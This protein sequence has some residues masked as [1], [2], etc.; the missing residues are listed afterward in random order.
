MSIVL[1]VSMVPVQ[2]LAAETSAGVTDTVMETVPAEE[3][4]DPAAEES[5]PVPEETEA[6]TEETE[7]ATEAS[8]PAPEETRSAVEETTPALLDPSSQDMASRESAAGASDV[9]SE[10]Y[11]QE[12]VDSGDT[13]PDIE[14][15]VV[16]EKSF[17]WPAGYRF[18]IPA[19]ITLTVSAG[20]TLTMNESTSLSGTI[21]VENGGTFIQNDS[22]H[23][24]DGGV[25]RVNA[26]GTLRLNDT[27]IDCYSAGTLEV[28]GTFEA[29]AAA[30]GSAG[31]VY[32][33]YRNGV[34]GKVSGIP[35]G[36]LEPRCIVFTE[37]QLREVLANQAS[38]SYKSF[39]ASIERDLVLSSAITISSGCR[40]KV[41]SGA[42]LTLGKN[43]TLTNHGTF[44]VNDGVISSGG[45]INNYGWISVSD[46]FS[47][48]G[49][50]DQHSGSIT[51]N[52]TGVFN[53]NG[54]VYGTQVTMN[55][56]WY[57]PDPIS[58]IR[59]EKY[60]E[61][62]LNSGSKTPSVTADVVL[63]NSFTI[64]GNIHK[65]N[66]NATITI[67]AGKTLTLD[68]T[69]VFL[70][71]GASIV[72]EQG[73]TLIVNASL[74][75]WG[76]S[77]VIN[78]GTIKRTGSWGYII[79]NYEGREFVTHTEGV[80]S[81][82]L[83]LRFIIDNDADLQN[84][85]QVMA[86]T[87]Y[88]HYILLV[89]GD[90]D[91]SA[92]VTIPAN[93]E[94]ML[95]DMP[96]TMTI[97]EGKT[98]TNHGTL[99]VNGDQA[100]HNLGTVESDGPCSISGKVI[101]D[102]RFR[103]T[104]E[105][106]VFGIWE[107][108]PPEYGTVT[109]AEI[110]AG[111]K[112][113]GYYVLYGNATLERSMTLNGHLTIEAGRSLT[114]P[115]GVK[116][117]VAA[118]RSISVLSGGTLVMNGTY[119]LK[120]NA[121][122]WPSA[123]Y[124][125]T[126]DGTVGTITGIREED[127]QVNGLVRN[128]ANFPAV[129]EV[130]ARHPNAKYSFLY[131]YTSLELPGD[132]V[133]PE[134]CFFHLYGGAVLTIPKN[135]TLTN[136]GQ[137]H[138][139]N[140]QSVKNNGTV[141]NRNFFGVFGSMENAGQMH[142][143]PG[144]LLVVDPNATLTNSGTMDAYGLDVADILGTLSGNPINYHVI[145]H[146]EFEAM[147]TEAAAT[148]KVVTLEKAVALEKNLTIPETVSLEVFNGGSILVPKDVALTL[149]CARV[150][151]YKGDLIVQKG[152]TL[153]LNTM[154]FMGYNGKLLVD[155]RFTSAG[156]GYE[157]VNFFEY[158]PVPC[159]VTGVPMASQRLHVLL[160]DRSEYWQPG[161]ELFETSA[162]SKVFLE[163]LSDVTLPVDL[164]IPKNGYLLIEGMAQ[165]LVV[166][167][168]KKLTNHGVLRV[169]EAKSL[170]NY[171]T[172]DNH[173]YFYVRANLF[174]HGTIHM[175]PAAAGSA[176]P[177]VMVMPKWGYVENHG[178]VT[179][180]LGTNL[181]QNAEALWEGNPAVWEFITQDQLESAMAEA[182]EK[183]ETYTLNTGVAL[184]RTLTL[185]QPLTIGSNGHL[186]VPKGIALNLKANLFVN[187]GGRL[188]V[189]GTYTA[190]ED[191]AVYVR[192][193]NGHFSSQV[194]GIRNE[195]LMVSMLILTEAHLRDSVL[196]V[197]N[198]GYR[199]GSLDVYQSFTLTGDITIPANGLVHLYNGV[200]LTVGTG[201][202]LTNNGEIYIWEGA[203]LRN[204][205]TI[206]NNEGIF[207]RG[208]TLLNNGTL[209]LT[210][211]TKVSALNPRLIL[212]AGTVK[213][214][215]TVTMAKNSYLEVFSTWEG[216]VPQNNGG[217]ILPQAQ[218]L[219][220]EGGENR[221]V[222]IRQNA[223]IDLKIVAAGSPFQCVTWTS[224]NSAV[225]NPDRIENLGGGIYRV[226][227]T[228]TGKAKL[229]A[230][231]IDG[232]KLTAVLNMEIERADWSP[233]L[234]SK[235]VTVNPMLEFSGEVALMP[236]HNNHIVDCRLND[237]RFQV[238]Y[239]ES[240]LLLIGAK[241]PI[242]NG[243]VSAVL[244]VTCGRD[245]ETYTYPLTITVKNSAP[246]VTIKQE[247][248]LNLFYTD[249]SAGLTVT[250]KNAYVERVE[251]TD[252]EDFRLEGRT[253]RVTDLFIR[254]YLENPKLKPD[255]KATVLV[256]LRGYQQPVSTQITIGTTTGKPA[257]VT[258][259]ASGTV[260]TALGKQSL[261][262]RVLDK[263]TKAA[264]NL[265]ASDIQSVDGSFVTGWQVEDG[266]L[267]L[268]TAGEKG[269]TATIFL[270]RSNWTQSVKVTHKVTINAKL[271]TA[272]P[273]SSTLKLSSVFSGQSARTQV[274]LSHSNLT[275]DGFR[276]DNQFVSTAKAG[277][278]A[279]Q[280]ASKLKVFYNKED[281]TITAGIA[282]GTS[283]PKA[284][285]YTFSAVPV[286]GGTELKAVTIK[287]NV[288]STLP[289]IKLSGSSLKLNTRLSGSEAGKIG[290]TLNDTTGYGLKVVGFEGMDTY[291]SQIAMT[292]SG[293]S[294][295]A[296]LLTK[297]TGT[298]TYQLV[299]I[300]ADSLG[301]TAKLSPVKVT[302]Q[303]YDKDITVTTSAKGSLD[304]ICRD[305]AI[306]YTI[307][308][309]GNALDKVENVELVQGGE[310]FG[311]SSIMEDAKG[312]QIFYLGVNVGTTV[313]VKESY[314]VQ[315]R[316]TICG[317]EVLSKVF[318]VKVRQSALKITAPA[319]TY[320]LTQQAPIRIP[321]LVTAP[322]IAEIASVSLNQDKT[323]RELRNA[324]GET[325]L[326]GAM[327][328]LEVANPNALAPG[329]RYKLVLDITPF[330]HAEGAK[331][332]QVTVTITTA[333]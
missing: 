53:N 243:K 19:G 283:L 184:E 219:V 80:P 18:S 168:G 159:T 7:P 321:L 299:P 301:T 109:Q 40:V 211:D 232:K 105:L 147:I 290:V 64:T 291:K 25:F 295:S 21:I 166:P 223:Y 215:G 151:L 177:S 5:A 326:T 198:G 4:S 23:I 319:Q 45:L 189:A 113:N 272:K 180:H 292:W 149:K 74:S 65:L 143:Q 100:L 70:N 55:G 95:S 71:H 254:D 31:W 57:G 13:W 266:S 210:S 108:N 78:R 305:S 117:T 234:G 185:E 262:F 54:T 114:V 216:N 163:I 137:F 61:E 125:Q 60:L 172:I 310:W 47:N 10:E 269:G 306:L 251:L 324:L 175:L 224:G 52:R 122:G 280:E 264:L 89:H 56:T 75:C 43:C 222:D 270:R 164:T 81:S 22:L 196:V 104:N 106:N 183:G 230:T 233:R 287:V 107:G 313:S 285:T 317:Q 139:W 297:R 286:V 156:E 281:G 225:V 97:P 155:G 278:A 115:K 121:D 238:M 110:E 194:I 58:R 328:S 181:D 99:I 73:G 212:A 76:N 227:F 153:N 271:P 330:G 129:L 32:Q 276:N 267:V 247:G 2:A 59:N 85:V 79:A 152:G 249:S 304:S 320:Y 237:D 167:E 205:G 277:S 17:T 191:G 207:V 257:L 82:L 268:N 235:T 86:K 28:K 220:I 42:V 217:R 138:C 101:N 176:Q 228:Q 174:N 116:L 41:D 120:K 126:E 182:A 322:S 314:P 144:S 136:F 132:T 288:N 195:D 282:D 91:L 158:G 127:I 49:T 30:D 260:H 62:L 293:D 66:V 90:I 50:V 20:T 46:T 161:I 178:T 9:K 197:Q 307:T 265:Q 325:K 93:A 77:R 48:T 83:W 118:D 221:L 35:E 135:M 165:K 318:T 284:G 300:V 331:T 261:S 201:R 150:D 87:S 103:T 256:Y 142:L 146:G 273:V 188:E 312:K 245:G 302:V 332:T 131:V 38:H 242:K 248:K 173:G 193:E 187:A 27:Y 239:A 329:K 209:Q 33:S 240:G 258:D 63:E 327:L 6:T 128:A 69:T 124:L 134:N 34:W 213:N 186:L 279:W 1:V 8:T 179:F 206:R 316:Y 252:T 199:L 39:L 44:S 303:S 68:Q 274:T 123:I 333:K 311:I 130:V 16:L 259:P 102:G 67:P 15:N 112:K 29:P 308:K 141:E 157:V 26:G 244:S 190:T 263:S 92:D 36:H 250:A 154:I 119:E 253:L 140:G 289:K 192:Y 3:T 148:D 145:S 133:I 323:S 231:S 98:L 24:F 294:L 88:T 37:E 111:L 298:Y 246:A 203:V 204:E 162:H 214:N 241:Q 218:S 200:T 11:L 275:L 14:Y 51:V 171:G 296:K 208:G 160:R 96:S 255:T 309:V 226:H 236:T 12:L 315:F 170:Y 94:L 229:T 84:A 72:V 202:T 169:D